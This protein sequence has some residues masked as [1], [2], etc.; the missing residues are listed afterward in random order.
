MKKQWFLVVMI[1]L[2]VPWLLAGC[3]IAQDVYD[4][5]VAERDSLIAQLQSVQSELD[6]AKSN[7]ELAQ[8]ELDAKLSEFESVQKELDTAKA[9]LDS[10]QSEFDTTKSALQSVQAQFDSAKAEL[11]N[12][13][14]E[15]AETKKVYPP[16]DFSS[17]SELREWLLSNDVS[18]RPASTNAENLYSKA[19]EIQEDALADGYRVSAWIDY[20][21]DEE[22][23]YVLCQAVVDGDVWVWNPE[24][25]ELVNFS[26][27]TGLLKLR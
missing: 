4:A 13:K 11:E 22:M 14:D 21:P 1:F 15:L 8:N 18:E 12:V 9:K 25:D 24:D 6:T 3:G 19:L 5:V 27:M 26:D 16:R 2:L 17:L 7:L 10:V 20:Y 23:F